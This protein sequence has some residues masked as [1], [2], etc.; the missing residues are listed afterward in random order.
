MTTADSPSL[1]ALADRLSAADRAAPRHQPKPQPPARDQRR[2]QH[3]GNGAARKAS[4]APGKMTRKAYEKEMKKIQGELVKLQLWAKHTGAKVVVLFEGRD[5]AGKGG[6]IKA[7]TE[8]TSP[9][10]FRI[11]ALPAPSEREK[12]QMYMQRYIAHMPAAGEVVLFG[13]IPA[14]PQQRMSFAKME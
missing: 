3:A 9:R 13:C 2:R 11:A 4:A 5:A 14:S 6:V 8:R 1:I 10:S 12:T 7:L